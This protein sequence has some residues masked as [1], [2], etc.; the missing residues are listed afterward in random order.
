MHSQNL[1]LSGC[2]EV[3]GME[4]VDRIHLAHV[5]VKSGGIVNRI[6]VLEVVQNAGNI[7]Y[8]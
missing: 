6:L 2:S 7:V 1:A 8:G 3:T 4:G 5:R